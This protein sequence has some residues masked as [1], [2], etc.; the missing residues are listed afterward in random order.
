MKSK[1][2]PKQDSYVVLQR[3][4]RTELGLKGNELTVYAIIYGFSQDGESV[5]KGGYGYLADWTGLS[6]NGARN[7]VKE[8]VARGLLKELKTMVGGI[9]VNQY[10]ANRTPEPKPESVPE[11]EPDPYKNC[12][13]TKIVP[14]Q[15]LEGYP[16]KKCIQTP[17]K[18]VDRK[19]IG[20]SIGKSIYPREERGTDT[21]D[22]LDAAREEAMQHFRAR[23]ELDTLERRYDPAQLKELLDNIVDMYCCPCMIQSV[24]QYPQTTQSI[25][26]RLDELTSQHIEYVLD[27]LQNTTQPIHN[28]RGYIRATLLNA[29][30][31][32]E[33]YYQAQGNSLTAS[34]RGGGGR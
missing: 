11:K 5:Y 31:T 10:V 34:A 8:L 4:M 2:K 28:I 14:V 1:T 27:A 13:P 12:T 16:Y 21:M 19:P 26:K 7:I 3:W 9:L 22:G 25:R 6:E 23:L 20:K 33:H 17:T 24:G 15:K 32:M 30:T 29:P 18:S